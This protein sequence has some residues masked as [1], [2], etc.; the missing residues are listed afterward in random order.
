M[1]LPDSDN[2]NDYSAT[3][4]DPLGILTYAL[5]LVDEE[6]SVYRTAAGESTP[7]SSISSFKFDVDGFRLN[8]GWLEFAP[9]KDTNI[10]YNLPIDEITSDSTYE[11][12]LA[13]NATNIGGVGQTI[14]AR[15]WIS[16]TVDQRTRILNL[17]ASGNTTFTPTVLKDTTYTKDTLDVTLVDLTGF[18]VEEAPELSA[19]VYSVDDDNNFDST[20]GIGYLQII[21]LLEDADGG[22]FNIDAALDDEAGFTVQNYE[23]TPEDALGSYTTDASGGDNLIFF[24]GKYK[25]GEKIKGIT[26]EFVVGDQSK[27]I[28]DPGYSSAYDTDEAEYWDFNLN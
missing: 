1:T 12:P 13:T 23:A 27:S 19:I 3:L 8:N 28:L 6:G 16:L 26:P 5:N 18:L 20:V 17:R 22:L 10:Y 7:D 24:Y 21:E 14:T 15:E 9:S 4:T 2:S 25:S 11:D